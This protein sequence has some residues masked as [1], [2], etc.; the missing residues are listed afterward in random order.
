MSIDRLTQ[1]DVLKY[2][3]EGIATK[4][5]THPCPNEFPEDIEQLEH[6]LAVIE[7]RIAKLRTQQPELLDD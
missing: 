5:G 7:R 4:L 6:D 2:A 1:L 3:R